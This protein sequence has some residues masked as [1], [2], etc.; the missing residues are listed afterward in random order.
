VKSIFISDSGG[1]RLQGAGAACL[2]IVLADRAPAQLT[3]PPAASANALPDLSLEQLVNVQVTSVSK[4]ATSLA[5]SPAAISVITADDI[6]RLGIVTLPDALRLVPGMDVA[7]INANEAAVSVRGFNAQFGDKLLVLIDG[8]SVYTPASGGVFWNSQTVMLDDL[9]RI[10]VIRGPGAVLWGANAVDGVINIVSKSA[11]ETQGLLVTGAGG[12][13]IQP[14]AGVRYGGELASNVY[15]RVYAQRSDEAEYQETS[16]PGAGDFWDTTLAGFRIDWEP[17][18]QNTVTFQGDYYGDEAGEP[19]RSVSLAPP[20]VSYPTVTEYNNGGNLLGRW[21]H[22]FSASSQLTLQAYFDHVEQDDSYGELYQNTYDIDL[23]D[24]FALGSWNDFVAGAGYRYTALENTPSFQLTWVPETFF[25]TI[26]NFFAQ[27]EITVVPDRLRLTVGGKLEYNNLADWQPQPDGRVLWTPT[28]K[29][30]IWAS[31]ALA[32]ATPPLVNQSA[33]LNVAAFQPSASSPPALVSILGNPNIG[34]ERLTDYEIGYRNAVAE[35]LSFDVTGFYNVYD[36]LIVAVP[37]PTQI[38][39]SPG[40]THLLLPSTWE[41]AG[42]ANTYGAEVSGQWRVTES[43]RLTASYSFLEM[44]LNTAAQSLGQSPEQQFQLRSYLDLP[45]HLQL[46]GAFYFVDRCTSPL[47]ST[48]VEIP[49]YA[50]L[51]LGLVWRPAHW[52]EVGIWGQNLSQA[53]HVEFASQQTQVLT[54]I[55]RSV[56]AK[57]TLRF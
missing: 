55:P 43:W 37:N 50:R 51:D 36:S 34:V 18:T 47:T 33:R 6:D 11:R 3:N 24:H 39:S 5:D 22:D 19:S 13:E 41:N 8:R 53:W 16:G 52:L 17:P 26:Y 46:N 2:L 32:T 49:T 29:Q 30:S 56:M 1:R 25:N 20:G 28:E 54:E 57:I 31:A 15:Y 12:S 42:Q 38:E 4:K 35:R 21:T 9:D 45:H 40:P 44:Q 10:E 27:D 48:V 14:L 7:Q 23:Q